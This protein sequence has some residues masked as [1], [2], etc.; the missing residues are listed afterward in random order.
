MEASMETGMLWF[1]NDPRSDL[2][3]KV[4]RAVDYYQKKYG[5]RPEVCFV[6]PGAVNDVQRY[7]GIEIR[8]SQ[9]ILPN[10]LWIG[11]LEK[12]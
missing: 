1:D 3:A 12:T 7:N 8:S 6:H 9:M 4:N 10:H 5:K 11:L 2:F